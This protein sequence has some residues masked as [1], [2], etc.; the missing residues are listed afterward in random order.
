MFHIKS[1]TDIENRAYMSTYQHAHI[2][3][4]VNIFAN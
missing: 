1:Y 2:H 4:D 3:I